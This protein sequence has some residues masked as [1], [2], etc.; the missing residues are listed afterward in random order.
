VRGGSHTHNRD[1]PDLRNIVP[2]AVDREVTFG[3]WR[4]AWSRDPYVGANPLLAERWVEECSW[5]IGGDSTARRRP[6][7]VELARGGLKGL[8]LVRRSF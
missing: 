7:T 4:G 3:S 2:A 8:D 1:V 5:G 6:S